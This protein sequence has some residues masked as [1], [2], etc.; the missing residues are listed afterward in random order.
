M[1][2]PGRRGARTGRG[3]NQ[4]AQ[5]SSADGRPRA[6][7]L[8]P[9]EKPRPVYGPSFAD[10][11]FGYATA[12]VESA[13][14]PALLLEGY[15]DLHDVEAEVLRGLKFLFLGYK[16]AG[17]SA[18]GEHLRL[19]A[20]QQ[21]TLFV[22]RVF[23]A[24]FPFAEFGQII[25]G[26]SQGPARYPAAW[27][28]LI[29]LRLMGLAAADVGATS[30]DDKDFTR[31]VELLERI[32]LMPTPSVQEIVRKSSSRS[33]KASLPKVV[34]TDFGRQIEGQGTVGVGTLVEVLKRI[35]TR[36]ESQ[37]KHFLV[38]DG[39]DDIL[40]EGKVQYESL[41]ALVLEASRLNLAFREARAPFKVVVLCRTD[42]YERLPGP[43]KNKI[44]QDSA[45]HL[46][47][48]HDPSHP[49]RS[50]LVALANMKA[51]VTYA[52]IK[53]VMLEYLP[54]LITNGPRT[55]ALDTRKFLLNHT[56]HT[57]RDLL[58][59]LK[60]IQIFAPK[61]PRTLTVEQ[62]R[63]GVRSYSVNYFLPEI[64]DELVGHISIEQIDAGFTVLG[65]CQAT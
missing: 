27:S 59:L 19:R 17:K 32:G 54:G 10:F 30:A 48:Y 1:A 35:L 46:D 38:I 41:A 13:A 11:D 44:R 5:S 20:G 4:Q 36:F 14:N 34:E 40:L 3:G 33:F 12:E 16:G 8:F 23:L 62:V 49:D 57:P 25:Q 55:R 28:W 24:D 53:D 9:I 7:K 26:P 43:N 15:L 50:A 39:L 51:R 65:T 42:I 64:K 18:I 63:S 29:A 22:D 61:E 31:S 58:Q 45:V 52:D 60:Q 2:A 56:R 6:K 47:W 21:A 37:S